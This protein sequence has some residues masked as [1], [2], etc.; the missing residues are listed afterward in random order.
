MAELGI[1]P[2]ARQ[3]LEMVQRVQRDPQIPFDEQWQLFSQ[4]A[5]E[6]SAELGPM[7]AWWPPPDRIAGSNIGRLMAEVGARSYGELQSW[8]VAHRAEFWSRMIQRLGIDFAGRRKL[9]SMTP[10]G[11]STRW[12]PGARLNIVDS[13]FRASGCTL[14]VAIGREGSDT[15]ETRTYGELEAL[16]NRV[17]NGLVDRGLAPGR[18]IALYMP[19]TIECVAAYLGVIRAGSFVVSIADSFAAHELGRRLSLGGA[20]AIV[21]VTELER[22]GKRIPLYDKVIEA[23]GPPAI[24]SRRA[25]SAPAAGDRWRADLLGEDSAAGRRLR[26]VRDDQ[27]PLLLRHHR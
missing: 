1:D 18:G 25:R 26:P 9:P 27:R 12:L 8:S 19:M 24:G 4:L 16:V 21:T 2:Q 15:I 17:A 11:P 7:P 14:A 22:A 6:R 20:Q 13:C 3:W 10:A 5:A 23:E